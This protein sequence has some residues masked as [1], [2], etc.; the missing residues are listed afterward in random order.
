M[1][2]Q[3]YTPKEL[4]AR[5]YLAFCLNDHDVISVPTVIGHADGTTT[6]KIPNKII[7]VDPDIKI[8]DDIVD[9]VDRSFD[10]CAKYQ[11]LE[12]LKNTNHLNDFKNKVINLFLSSQCQAKDAAMMAWLPTIV[13]QII[14]DQKISL[15]NNSLIFQNQMPYLGTVGQKIHVQLEI[16]SSRFL[17]TINCWSV[18]GHDNQGHFVN[19]LTKKEECTRDG[20]YYGRIKNLELNCYYNSIPTTVLHFVK[21]IKT[22]LCK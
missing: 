15:L 6:N 9:W 2:K 18:L 22:S 19:F 3:F 14:Q 1:T 21:P 13:N 17:N 4:A 5:A 10:L 16:L 11:V 8:S 12:T 20:R 7:M